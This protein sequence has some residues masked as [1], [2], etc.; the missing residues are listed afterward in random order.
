MLTLHHLENSRSQR[1]LWLLEELGLEYKVKKYKRDKVTQLAPPELVKVHP[2]GKS[3]VVTDGEL[4]VAESGAI[5]EY[6]LGNYGNG[7]LVPAEGTR[8]RLAYTYWMHY[9]EGSLMPFM[10]LSLIMNKIETA[11]MP[12]FIRPVAKGIAGKV[13]SGYLD[14]NVQRNLEFLESTLENSSWFCGEEFTAADIQ[15]SFPLEAAEV[16]ASLDSN[17][18]QLAG[19]LTRIR[20]R[21]AYQAALKKGGPYQL[22]GG[23]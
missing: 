16:R 22:M 20:Q 21:P 18:P 3:P 8:E 17:Y 7:T 6:L 15:M 9:A 13:K 11:P 12:F 10:V 14:T 2:L 1:I 5:I 23:D 19:Y 4:T